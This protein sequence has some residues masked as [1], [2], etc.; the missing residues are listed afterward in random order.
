MLWW[1]EIPIWRS[2]Q[3]KQ[4]QKKIEIIPT[5]ID[6]NRYNLKNNFPSLPPFRAGER[7]GFGNSHIE[8]NERISRTHEDIL[9]KDSENFIIGW[10]GTKSTFEKHLAP[11]KEWLVEFLEK[12]SDSELHVMGIPENQNWH[13]RVKWIPW[14]ESSEIAFIQNLDVGIMPLQDSLWEK[15]KC[16]YKL[17]QYAACGIPGVASDVGMNREVTIPN[18]TG[19][20]ANTVEEWIRYILEMKN[21]PLKKQE[22][23]ANARKLVEEKYCIQ[24]TAKKWIELLQVN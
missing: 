24:V 8:F 11:Q 20:L 1:R 21:N 23:G 4:V 15:G 5:V 12:N 10:I 2:G 19:F 3:R 7:S 17:I 6:L 18:Q 14:S 22:L 9:H 16:A 13:E